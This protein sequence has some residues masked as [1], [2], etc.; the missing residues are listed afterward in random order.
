MVLPKVAMEFLVLDGNT[1]YNKPL[2][3]LYQVSVWQEYNAIHVM[4]NASRFFFI[5]NQIFFR[6]ITIKKTNEDGKS[7]IP[8]EDGKSIIP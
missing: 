8:Y 6:T 2:L 3:V 1:R 5:M 4:V 7:I